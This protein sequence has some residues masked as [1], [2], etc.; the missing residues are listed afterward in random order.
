MVSVRASEFILTRREALAEAM[1]RSRCR[2]K[3]FADLPDADSLADGVR[4]ELE[5]NPSSQPIDLEVRVQ[6]KSAPHAARFSSRDK[7]RICK[8]HWYVLILLHQ[9]ARTLDLIWGEVYQL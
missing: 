3:G 5:A 7:C 6:S 9:D 2:K 1:V 4:H 8:I